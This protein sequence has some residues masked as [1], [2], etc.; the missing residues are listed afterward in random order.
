MK[1]TF[2][3][4]LISTIVS[5]YTF[6]QSTGK[7]K[8]GVFGGINIA[9][10]RASLNGDNRIEDSKIGP[11]IGILAEIII[12]KKFA[13]QPELLYSDLGWKRQ[14]TFP[15]DGIRVSINP[16]YNLSYISLPLLLKA[17]VD[18]AAKNGSGLAFYI[19]PQVG[20]LIGADVKSEK[21]PDYDATNAFKSFDF[22]GIGGAEYFI[23]KGFGVN[24][25][26]QFGFANVFT[27]EEN[28]V[29]EKIFNQGIMVKNRSVVIALCYRF[30]Y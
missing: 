27:S 7:V 1:K 14:G 26:Y 15:Y 5:V 24:V 22:S 23:A 4:I 2:L 3:L 29:S 28:R 10:V 16:K 19:G 30:K 11:T 6:S 13:V 17:K 20:L 12:T 8:Y 18:E 21:G 25:H 9:H